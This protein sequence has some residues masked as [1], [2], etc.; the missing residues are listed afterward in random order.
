M[1][2]FGIIGLL[3]ISFAIWIKNDKQQDIIFIFGGIFLLIYSI[4][5]KDLVFIFLQLIFIL[6]AIIELI[7]IKKIK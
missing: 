7:K 2:I 1:I 3:A 4:F 6:S 5:I